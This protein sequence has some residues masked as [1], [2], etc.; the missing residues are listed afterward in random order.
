MSSGSRKSLTAVL[1]MVD[2]TVADGADGHKLADDLFAVVGVLDSEPMLN[3]A[4]TEP[5]VPV[6]AKTSMLHSLFEGKVGVA[7]LTVVEVAV[8]RRWSRGGDLSNGI[9]RAAI[10]AIA[11]HADDAGKLDDLEDELFRFGRILES[12]PELRE[13]LTDAA[14]P[15]EAKRELLH[16][17]LSRKA[18][19]ATLALLDQLVVGRHRTLTSGLAY[20]QTVAAA[21]RE[22]LLATAWVAAPLSEEHKLR[23]TGALAAQYSQQVHLNVVI[24]ADV[25]GGVRVAIADDVIDSSV[26]SRLTDAHRRL[27]H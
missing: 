16:S 11:A 20:Y 9:E 25:L 22:M 7:A 6:E 24:D 19:R 23:L 12:E 3:R 2:E 27:I 21:R 8:K 18:G 13:A 1:D 15:L 17:L 14:A 5:A 26:E 10:T 4:L